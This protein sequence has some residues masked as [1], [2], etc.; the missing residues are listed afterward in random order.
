MDLAQLRAEMVANGP[1][2]A[3]VLEEDI[4]PDDPRAAP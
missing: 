2:W 1:A 3:E 4:D